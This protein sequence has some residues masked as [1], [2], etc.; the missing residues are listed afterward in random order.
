VTE[1]AC[2]ALVGLDNPHS[3]GWLTTL[4]HC[5]AVGRLLVCADGPCDGVDQVYRNV[6]ELLAGES[7]DFA[8]VSTRND[9][10]PDIAAQLLEAGV[11]VIVEKPVARTAAE[12]ARLNELAAAKGGHWATAFMNRY[13]PIAKKLHA[14]LAEGVLGDIVSI[15]GRMVTSTV[16][17][18][19]PEH[20]LFNS[21]QAG[22]GILHWLA[23][24]T[25]DLIRYITGLEYQSVSAHMATL[26]CAD[27]DVEDVLAASFSMDNGAIGNIHAGY[28]LPRRYGDIYLCFRG[29]E[30]DAIWNMWDWAGK[31]DRLV[32]QSRVEG[33]Q[34][35][36]H[37]AYNLSVEEAPGYGGASGVNF[38]ADFIAASRQNGSFV[39]DG[40]DA[41]EAM[42][43][44]E[45]AYAAAAGRRQV[46]LF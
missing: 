19:N 18:R 21:A 44:V 27:I 24:H 32:V 10:A 34:E 12:V 29:T 5:D 22:G 4:Q 28:V 43:F 23:I 25:V 8:L 1:K 46:D 40:K 41:F 17:Q 16:Q 39:T 30:G 11:P 14:L 13:H 7:L 15:E 6:S 9:R 26:S 45:A 35:E 42:R 36:E 33:W 37:R 20:W 2:S 38:V 31:G 3:A